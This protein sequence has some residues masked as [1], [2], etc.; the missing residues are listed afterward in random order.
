[1]KDERDNWLAR[2]AKGLGSAM[3]DVASPIV[4]PVEPTSSH[5]R[6]GI[7]RNGDGRY[8]VAGWTF[9]TLDQALEFEAGRA[10]P[11]KAAP[12]TAVVP[13][14]RQDG[15]GRYVVGGWTFSTLEQATEF[16]ANRRPPPPPAPAPAPR[17]QPVPVATASPANDR[18]SPRWISQRELLTAGG[19]MFGAGMIYFGSAPRHDPRHDQSRIDPALPVDRRG[20]PDGSTLGYWPSYRDL[21]PSARATY[22]A[23]LSGGRRDAPMASGY[24]FLFLYGLE[25]RLLI[26]RAHD[27]APAIFTELRR[28]IALHPEDYSFQSHASKLLALSA[29]YDDGDV[30]PP[31]SGYARNWEPELPLDLRIRLGRRVRDGMPLGAEDALRWVLALPDVHLRT[32]GQR[33]FDELLDLWSMRFAVRHPGGLTIRRPQKTIRHEYHA[34]SGKFSVDLRLDDLP[35][36]SGVSAPLG[37]LKAMLDLCVDDLS[38]FSRLVGRDVDAR[39]RL[40]ADL[41]LPPE[42]R[43]NGVALS[44]CRERLAMIAAD[45]NGGMVR[46][47]DLARAL[48]LA[49]DAAADKLPATTARQ[50]GSALDALDHG[51]EPDRRYGAG[52]AL[53]ID[54][55][56]AVFAS[57]GGGAVDHDRPAYAAARTMV[58]IATLVAAADGLVVPAEMDAIARRVRSI[59]DLTDQE[60]D[61]L[62]AGCRA[63]AADPPKLRA[64][65]RRMADVPPSQR[66][67]IVAAAVDA[68]L[69]DG[70]VQA[71]EVQFLEALHLA[72]GLPAAALYAALHRG[73]EDAGPVLVD[74]GRPQDVVPIGPDSDPSIVAIDAARLERI[75]GETHRVSA[76]LATIFVE[77]EPEPVV[78]APP[79]ATSAPG[80]FDGLDGPHADLLR[81]LVAGPMDRASFDRA[82]A[83]LRLMPDG[84]IETIN[85]WG[86][87]RL[88]EPVLED[89]DDIRVSPDVLDQLEPMGVAA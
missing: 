30:A 41:L 85:E 18:R 7:R 68:A 44:A 42:L 35:D 26:D 65:L 59:P 78:P 27:D 51:F 2:I 81:Q 16:E 21:H 32:P 64:A 36:I 8:V 52:A 50:I 39:G 5:Q 69:A 20:D 87:D 77:D 66:A 28:L 75:K 56:V 13:D 62:M 24:L 80:G 76:L 48:D 71:E 9:A 6:S 74:A 86:F 22:L 31:I 25:Q 63:L 60:A 54:T 37:P 34:A 40:H 1:M 46:A 73:T 84:A 53:R 58:E 17:S 3:S 4:T 49:V 11:A 29:L 55:P 14:I 88:G 79:P 45:G 23:W 89:D 72:L 15:A 70:I 61:R 47:A 82:T 12:A 57:P 19:V 43:A 38:A 67:S 10:E 33:C 83:A